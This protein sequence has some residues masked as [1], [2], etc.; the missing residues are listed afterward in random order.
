MSTLLALSAPRSIHA[1]RRNSLWMRSGSRCCLC[2]LCEAWLPPSGVTCRA[3]LQ[4]PDF[5]HQFNPASQS[6]CYGNTLPQPILCCSSQPIAH[7]T[8]PMR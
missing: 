2:V 7:G 3:Q 1:F 5:W 6:C 4:P 8:L